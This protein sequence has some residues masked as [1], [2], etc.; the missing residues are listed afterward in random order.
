MSSAERVESDDLGARAPLPARVRRVVSLVP[1]LTESVALTCPEVLIG[2][3]E[4]CTHPPELAVERVRGTKNPDVRRIVE[5]APEVVLCNREENRKL[6]VDRLRAAGIAV[7]VT[8]IRTVEQALTSL[9]RLFTAVMGVERPDWLGEAERVW[10]QPAPTPPRSAV[11]P[12]WRD[13]WMVVGADT[14]TGDLAARLG[15]RLVHADRGERYPT[16]AETE[17]TAGVEVAV[18]P[19]E[20]Y[21]FTGSDG[22]EKFPGVPVAL[23]SGRDLTWYGPSLV[24]A[25]ARLLDRL[26][27]AQ[28]P[29]NR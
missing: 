5:L 22:P 19:D 12:I 25:R 21:V 3:T 6:D 9:T 29:A 24:T 27:A 17:L 16:L 4:W 23:V 26:D 11:I 7:W 28:R 10:A 18:L 15:L 1:S 20:P 14:F 13:P 8:E 2:A